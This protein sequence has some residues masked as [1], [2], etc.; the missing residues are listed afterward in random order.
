MEIENHI[1]QLFD[2]LD[3]IEP[4][5]KK[6]CKPKNNIHQK[7][8]KSRITEKS[9]KLIETLIELSDFSTETSDSEV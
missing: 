9:K 2:I 3:R 1:Q 7:A 8:S 5:I 6:I 4:K